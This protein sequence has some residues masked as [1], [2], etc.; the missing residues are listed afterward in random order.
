G[1]VRLDLSTADRD[2]DQRDDL[3]VTVSVDRGGEPSRLELPWLDRPSGLARDV[4]EPESTL[5]ERSRAALRDI[6]RNRVEPGLSS[7][8]HVLALHEVLCR[9][10]GRARLRVGETEGLSC[11]TSDGAGRA[12]TTVVRALARQGEWVEALDALQRMD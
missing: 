9:E 2:G 5:S 6:L 4:D 7:S 10:P 3:V 8:R 12:A 11:G 1:E